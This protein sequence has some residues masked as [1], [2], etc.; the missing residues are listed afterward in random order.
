M[1]CFYAAIYLTC[2]FLTKQAL[3]EA[4]GCSVNLD[5]LTGKYPPILLQNSE[6]LYPDSETAD[7][8]RIL[9]IASGDSIE[10]YCHGSIRYFKDTYLSGDNFAAST[11]AVLTCENGV[12]ST[13]ENKQVA[14]EA[15]SC[16][17]RQEPRLVKTQEKCSVIGADGRTSELTN[18]YLIKIGW[19]IR[20]NFIDQITICQDE[21]VYG[22]IWTSH[23]VFGKNVNFRDI[24]DSRPS[25]RIDN[26]YLKRF[27]TWATS[28]KMN[29]Y[30][31]K[32]TQA[33]TI[34]KLLGHNLINGKPVIETSSSGTNYFAKGHL[35]PDAAFIYNLN[36]DATYYFMNVAPQ[37]QSFNNGNWK[38]LEMNT[39]DLASS[40][41]HD[42]TSVTGTHGVLQYADKHGVM[43][44]IYLY[45]NEATR[46]VPAPKYYWKVL[47]DA[48]TDSGVAFIGL[49]DPHA[50]E[51]P[52]ELCDNVCAQMPWVDWSIT[53]L[54]A[55]YMYCCSVESAKAAIPSMPDL[56][57]ANLIQKIGSNVNTY[58]MVD[59]PCTCTCYQGDGQCGGC[60]CKCNV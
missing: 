23:T 8:K 35:A 13:K 34:V 21:Q 37:F 42:V 29:G 30:Y 55:G 44:D 40:L 48:E 25:F 17:R 3:C 6:F 1:R 50:T 39:R 12:F 7:E 47:Y 54:D 57:P 49:N 27:F 19:K 38:A 5:S 14:V 41:G 15:V 16:N 36:Q 56:K 51:A 20:E 4:T 58:T 32:K 60:Q 31:S 43:T 18:L 53:E 26:S 11:S 33:N 22:T 2:T 28:T 45:L 10:L 59:G 46:Y 52:E 24:D 9:S